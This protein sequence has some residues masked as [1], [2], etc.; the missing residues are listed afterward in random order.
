MATAATQSLPS[1]VFT[2]H[3]T[4]DIASGSVFTAVALAI[5]FRMPAVGSFGFGQLVGAERWANVV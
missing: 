1:S 5:W 3:F 2:G 4:N